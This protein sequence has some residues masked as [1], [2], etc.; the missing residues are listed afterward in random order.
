MNYYHRPQSLRSTHPEEG[1]RRR[2]TADEFLQMVYAGIVGQSERVELIGGEIVQMSAKGNRHEIVRSELTIFWSDRRAKVY[3]IVS[4][5]PLRL[6]EHDEPEPDIIVFPASQNVAQ[7][8]AASVTLVV[9][10]ADSSLS[11]D[12]E[13]KAPLYAAF[14][15]RE[16][17]VIDPKTLTTTVHR[18]PTEKGYADITEAGPDTQLTPLLAPE[19]A[20]RLADIGIEPEPV[21]P[22]TTSP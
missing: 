15:V 8:T 4:E 9:E 1:S 16:Y 13:V 17:W 3:K 10:V 20:V 18:T 19:L 11:Y 2:W 12:L 7:V 21:T 22:S 14:G 5:P 6:S